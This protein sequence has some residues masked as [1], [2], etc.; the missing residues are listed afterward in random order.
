MDSTPDGPQYVTAETVP[1]PSSTAGHRP[2]P[3]AKIV[4]EQPGGWFGR[5]GKLLW[6]A[7]LVSIMINLGQRAAYRNYFS[8]GDTISEKYVSH[9][10]T[11]SDK[12]AILRVEGAILEGD[13]FVKRQIEQI[14]DDESV[15]AVVLRVDSPGGTVTASDYIYHHLKEL[16]KEREIPVVV[17]MGS[18]CASGG[19]YIAMAAGDQELPCVYAEPT[20]WTGSIGVVIPHFNVSGLLE[21]WDVQDDSI[22]SHPYKLL[23]SPTRKLSEDEREQETQILQELVDETFEGFKK[24]VRDGRLELH[25]DDLDKVSTGQVFTANQA[26]ESGLVDEIGFIEAAI[27]R[28]IEMANLSEDDVRVVKYTR[29]VSGLIETL[30]GTE[31]RQPWD[32]IDF[33]KFVDM[34]APRAYYL[35]TWMPA[36]LSNREP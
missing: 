13:G 33:A 2:P 14:R 34:T 7:L 16:I 28:A 18:L 29:R 26:K 35:C 11:A 8:S 19:Y 32:R 9:S 17:S 24:I 15:K 4:L 21:R 10:R 1:Q 6:I 23:G 12:V 20:T 22:A 25:D 27:D 36:V 31:A 5:L 30:A 3:P